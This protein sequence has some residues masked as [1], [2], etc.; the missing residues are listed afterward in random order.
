M[1]PLNETLS[2]ARRQD[3]RLPP[4]CVQGIGNPRLNKLFP[5]N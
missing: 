5:V 2:E 3:C 1:Y 4:H